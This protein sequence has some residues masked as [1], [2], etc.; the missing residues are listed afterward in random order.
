MEGRDIATVVFVD[1]PVKLY[2]QAPPDVRARRRAAERPARGHGVEDALRGRDARDA[3]TN[4]HR[5][6]P[7]AVVIDTGELDAEATLAA[8]LDAV[9]ELA[10]E[11]LQ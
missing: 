7:G 9:R 4:P 11:L 2:L 8:A 3:K 5:P 6:A 1:A 10:P